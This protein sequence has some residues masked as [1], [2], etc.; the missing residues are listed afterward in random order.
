M[1][2]LFAILFPVVFTPSAW[3]APC[4][5][6]QIFEV[7][8]KKCMD[9]GRDVV[10]ESVEVGSLDACKS[11]SFERSQRAPSYASYTFTRRVGKNQSPRRCVDSHAKYAVSKVVGVYV[12]A[13]Y[14]KY[15]FIYKN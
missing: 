15:R 2:M 7:T 11:L 1:K 6:K 8:T 3:A 5:I 12:D 14:V 13:D 9:L 4:E 10:R